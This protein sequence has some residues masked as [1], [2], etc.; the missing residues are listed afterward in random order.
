M[1]KLNLNWNKANIVIFSTYVFV[2]LHLNIRIYKLLSP[3]VGVLYDLNSC[4][5]A[6]IN[7]EKEN[8]ERI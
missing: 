3:P 5:I 1:N 2:Q 4:A 8:Y 7:S 6:Q